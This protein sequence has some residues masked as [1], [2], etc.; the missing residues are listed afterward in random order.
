MKCSLLLGAMVATLAGRLCAESYPAPD[1]RSFLEK[2]HTLYTQTSPDA[3]LANPKSEAATSPDAAY[4][5]LSL[6]RATANE[7]YLIRGE[8]IFAG[9]VL[10]NKAPDMFGGAP[11]VKSAMILQ[12]A[13]KLTPN[14]LA[15]LRA[16]HLQL[17]EKGYWF[18][19]GNRELGWLYG[20]ATASFGLFKDDPAFEPTRTQFMEWWKKAR[21]VGDLDENAGNY[22]SVGLTEL[23]GIVRAMGRED[24]LKTS[25]RWRNTFS[26]FRDMV[27]PSGH[28]PEWGDDYFHEGGWP[29]YVYIF[30]YASQLY[31]DPTFET[32]AR[33]ILARQSKALATMVHGSEHTD[34]HNLGAIAE[35]L[36]LLDLKPLIMT[37]PL[38]MLSGT[39]KRYDETGA[40][41]EDK[42]MLRPSQTP[43]APAI[44]MDLYAFGDHSHSDKKGSI[45]YYEVDNVPIFPG[46]YGRH[47]GRQTGE[48]GNS[49]YLQKDGESFP[50]DTWKQDEW[51]TVYLPAWQIPVPGNPA[52]L[53]RRVLT[54]MQYVGGVGDAMQ[55]EEDN[56][57]KAVKE[58][59]GSI[60]ID[61][62]RLVGPGGTQI[63]D[64]FEDAKT[65]TPRGTRYSTNASHGHQSLE[66]AAPESRV[67]LRPYNF[68]FDASAYKVV[69]YDIKRTGNAP[70]FHFRMTPAANGI[71]MYG[72]WHA[73]TPGPFYATIPEAKTQNVG[74]DCYAQV[75]FNGYGTWDS[76]LTRQ[77]VLTREGVL[78]IRD[79]FVPGPSAA[80]WTGGSVWQLPSFIERGENWFA[81]GMRED[82]SCDPADPRTYARGMLVKFTGD[83]ATNF[84]MQTGVFGKNNKEKRYIAYSK[85]KLTPGTPMAMTSVVVPLATPSEATLLAA[86]IQVTQ[87]AAETN[88]DIALAGRRIKVKVTATDW[89][90][91]R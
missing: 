10:A 59:G 12:T 54:Q 41:V 24:D 55:M 86:G 47:V 46:G 74:E 7:A 40:E 71:H 66:I 11:I 65:A 39:T 84:G 90:V 81:G 6:W 76:K 78:V 34:V 13:G 19:F 80:G 45:G 14:Q 70:V 23:I 79:S 8:K 53:N 77:I 20:A 73:V 62:L 28:M 32:A 37:S 87:S 48:G 15:W 68:A 64:D 44:M 63:I 42:L 56:A 58:P 75:I 69:C 31:Q 60:L 51:K 82:F 72:G 49:F 25:P 2:Y 1:Y 61:N 38:P 26:R 16:R 22:S 30:A 4:F 36:S 5:A 85:V 9:I 67:M 43:G 17:Q 83:A 27:T 89:R 50:I 35:A 57:A 88:A 52:E 33:K 29:A 3:W 18:R 21:A 91:E